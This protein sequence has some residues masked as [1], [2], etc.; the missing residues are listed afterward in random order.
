MKKILLILMTMFA[1]GVQN[2][3]AQDAP[4]KI[5]TLR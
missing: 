3:N 1:F 4:L 2:V 5:V